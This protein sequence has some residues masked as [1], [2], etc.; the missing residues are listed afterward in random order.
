[1]SLRAAWFERHHAKLRLYC[2]RMA[3]PLTGVPTSYVIQ[4]GSFPNGSNLVNFDAGNTALTLA[5]TNVPAGAYF[6]RVYARSA[7]CSPPAFL[8]PSSNEILLSVASAPSGWSGPIVCRTLISGPGGYHHDETQTWIVGGPARTAGPRTN[9]PVQW[10]AHGSGGYAASSWTINAT[11][12]IDFSVTTVASTGIPVFDR[13]TTLIIIDD[14][15]VGSPASFDLYEIEFPTIVAS[16]ATATSVTGTWSRATIGGDS[17]QQPGG[18]NG[19]LSCTW[20]LTF[21]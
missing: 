14:G 8:S 1:M 2:D 21:R 17:P 4:V 20:S 6:V 12:T 5:A 18:A 16:S 13:T 10:S 19:T 7:S 3:A 15:I 11:A 9:Y